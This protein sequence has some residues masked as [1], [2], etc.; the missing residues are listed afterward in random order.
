MPRPRTYRPPDSR[1][2]AMVK[3]KTKGI[4]RAGRAAEM[5]A[6]I[7]REDGVAKAIEVIE[8]L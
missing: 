4:L 1:L 7:A 8:G 2:R 5:A 6:A 3:Q